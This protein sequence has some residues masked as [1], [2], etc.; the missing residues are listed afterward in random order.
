M[1]GVVIL[2][3]GNMVRGVVIFV[4]GVVIFVWG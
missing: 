2:C 3:G 1:W 4:L